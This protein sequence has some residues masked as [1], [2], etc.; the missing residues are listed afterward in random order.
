[1][2]FYQDD[3]ITLNIQTGQRSVLLRGVKKS[4]T[5]RELKQYYRDQEDSNLRNFDF[6]FLG[7]QMQD[8]AILNDIGIRDR[9]TVM[10]VY[11]AMGGGPSEYEGKDERQSFLDESVRKKQYYNQYTSLSDY[12]KSNINM[13]NI[14]ENILV[15]DPHFVLTLNDLSDFGV[16]ISGNNY[17]EVNQLKELKNC[18]K[19]RLQNPIIDNMQTKIATVYQVPKA[20]VLITDIYY[21]TSN[22]GYVITD[23]EKKGIITLIKNAKDFEAKCK[24]EFKSFKKMIIT[25]PPESTDGS[26]VIIKSY[27]ISCASGK[28]CGKWNC[29]EKDCRLAGVVL[30]MKDGQT[31]WKCGGRSCRTGYII[32]KQTSKIPDSAKSTVGA[33]HGKVYKSVFNE[34]PENIVGSGFSRSK[35]VWKFGSQSFNGGSTNKG[36]DKYHNSG[37]FMNEVESKWVEKAIKNWWDTGNQN[38]KVTES[39]VIF[40]D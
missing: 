11:M 23:Y 38:T 18:I 25:P 6:I 39:I 16:N 10:I 17:S 27:H 35:G 3:T 31:K 21:G 40:K 22:I 24:K 2:A 30:Y 34:E 29:P 5:V 19:N 15:Q 33:I 8:N 26:Y 7:K 28:A 9:A 20:R 12:A 36:K 14:D 32:V 13:N 4:W 37:Y 1:M